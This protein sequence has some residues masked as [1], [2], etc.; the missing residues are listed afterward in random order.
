MDGIL[1]KFLQHYKFRMRELDSALVLAAGLGNADV[2][3]LLLDL[4]A[5]INFKVS[6]NVTSLHAASASGHYNLVKKLI[7][8]EN[9]DLNSI[10]KD[11]KE[12][13]IQLAAKN[14]HNEVVLLLATVGASVR[15]RNTKRQT[16]LN[17]IKKNSQI[18]SSVKIKLLKI[19]REKM[20]QN[21][22]VSS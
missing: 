7:M 5:N 12:T 8:V 2:V 17:L 10:T 6:N 1:A 19:L 14:A 3:Q 22:V 16:V 13:P 21:D 4:E 20:K 15:H 9:I 18:Q 11:L